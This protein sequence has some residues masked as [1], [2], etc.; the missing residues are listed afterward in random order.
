MI[1]IPRDPETR[2]HMIAEVQASVDMMQGVTGFT[3]GRPE[4][5]G[6]AIGI[7]GGIQD[8]VQLDKVLLRM[9][10]Q[11]IAAFGGKLIIVCTKTDQ[12][13]RIARLTGVRGQA[14]TFIDDRIFTDEQQ[15]QA[16]IFKIRLDQY[17]EEDGMPEHFTPGW[18]APGG[19]NWAV[20]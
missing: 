11:P 18:T 8:D 19:E 14:P 1:P 17:P 13:W 2:D 15:A 12:E 20:V 9:R 16:E 5:P 3:V 7:H 10:A 6:S 4:V